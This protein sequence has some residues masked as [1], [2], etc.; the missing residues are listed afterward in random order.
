M[1]RT[2]PEENKTKLPYF[3]AHTTELKN[4]KKIPYT[5]KLFLTMNRGNNPRRDLLTSFLRDT[6]VTSKVPSADNVTLLQDAALT[7]AMFCPNLS[8]A[9]HQ[10]Q[11]SEPRKRLSCRNLA[12]K[13]KV[14]FQLAVNKSRWETSCYSTVA[15]SQAATLS[16]KTL[17]KPVRNLSSDNLPIN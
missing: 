8:K 2:H 7:H 16:T 6:L 17:R 4:V 14:R 13:K 15:T 3:W 5:T 10:G 9:F 12:K 1:V 11:Q